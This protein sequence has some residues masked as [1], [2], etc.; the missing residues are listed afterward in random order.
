MLQNSRV[1][2]GRPDV[3]AKVLELMREAGAPISPNFI[4][5]RLGISWATA[6][7]I[8][9]KLAIEGKVVAMETL[10]SWVFMLPKDKG[11][12]EE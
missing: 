4:A 11:D 6:R 2:V 8:L 5:K 1:L 10:K 12:G 3:E 9:F 7:S